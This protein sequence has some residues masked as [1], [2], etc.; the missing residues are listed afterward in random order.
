MTYLHGE[1]TQWL[2]CVALDAFDAADLSSVEVALYTGAAAPAAL[3][4]RLA[5]RFRVATGTA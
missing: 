1:V 3:L 5:A 4:E 2:R